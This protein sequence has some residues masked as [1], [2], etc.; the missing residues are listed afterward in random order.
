MKAAQNM[1]G[2]VFNYKT[3]LTPDQF[4]QCGYSERKLILVLD[5]YDL[6]KQVKR[7]SKVHKRLHLNVDPK[8]EHPCDMAIKD[9]AVCDH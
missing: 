2:T 4:V 3:Q 5:A 9:Y 6:V 1:L 7:Q 8:W